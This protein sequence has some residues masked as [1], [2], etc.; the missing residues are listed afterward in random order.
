MVREGNFDLVSFAQPS[1]YA[2]VLTGI[3]GLVLGII[4]LVKSG[5]SKG[6]AIIGI[7]ASLPALAFFAYVIATTGTIG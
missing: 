3:A 7:C 5:G 4:A 1:Y 2:M 6:K